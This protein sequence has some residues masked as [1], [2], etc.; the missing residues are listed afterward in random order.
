MSLESER[1]LFQ[2]TSLS[3]SKKL[4]IFSALFY[5]VFSYPFGF[6]Q[7]FV[8]RKHYTYYLVVLIYSILKFCVEGL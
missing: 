5:V 2:T 4:A 3:F 6:V 1:K 8:A 7:F